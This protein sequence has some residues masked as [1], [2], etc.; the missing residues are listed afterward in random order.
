[1]AVAL[2]LLALVIGALIGM[3]GVGGVLLPP[4]LV[5]LGDLSV[6]E[7]TATSTWAFLFTGVVGTIAY[8]RQGVVPWPMLR[9]LGVGVVPAAF[10]GAL[11]SASLPATALML[12][13]AAL[14]LLVGVNQLLPG[15]RHLDVGELGTVP[16][17]GIGAF[18][19]LGSALTGTGGPVLLVPILLLLGVAPLKA[20]A[21]SQAVQLPVVVAGSI[22]FLQTGLVDVRLGTLLGVVAALGTVGG[23]LLATRVPGE[24]LRKVV[25]C[26]CLA[27]G[28]LILVRLLV[29]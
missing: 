12:G 16:L 24:A 3:V 28:T 19:G 5:A 1:M 7:A 9:R 18:V 23:A 4:G 21:V 27:A 11:V 29:A 8:A 10:L 17:V 15:A 26:A 2:G 6:H 25:A 13:L 14:T 20:V 22:G